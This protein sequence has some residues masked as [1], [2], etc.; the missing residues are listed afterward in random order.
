MVT[1][2]GKVR[3]VVDESADTIRAATL[4]LRDS[5]TLLLAVAGAAIVIAS[6]ALV[7]AVIK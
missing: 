3:A 4:Q 5:S 7:V 2:F 1:P 6:I